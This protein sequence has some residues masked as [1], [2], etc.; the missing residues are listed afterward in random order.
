MDPEN[1]QPI[2]PIQ[3]YGEHITKSEHHNIDIVIVPADADYQT[4]YEDI[5]NDNLHSQTSP[6]DI[7]GELELYYSS[8]DDEEDNL[9]NT[10]WIK[11]YPY[12]YCKQGATMD[13]KKVAYKYWSE[14]WV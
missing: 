5:D 7:S 11:I 14:Q 13:I 4:D 1:I 3:F 9:A 8:D 10:T 6:S 2:R 12:Q